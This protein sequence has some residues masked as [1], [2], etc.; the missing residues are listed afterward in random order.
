MTAI[1]TGATA[2]HI[3]IAIAELLFD[4]LWFDRWQIPAE[5]MKIQH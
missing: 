5:M 1:F 3:L 2:V 4:P